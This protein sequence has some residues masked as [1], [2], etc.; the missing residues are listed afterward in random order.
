MDDDDPVVASYDVFL[1]DP[2]ASSTSD[3][4]SRLFVLQYP[5]QFR[6]HY[7]PYNA[8][9]GQAPTSLRV[10]PHTGFIE[11]DVPVVTH[12]YY[13][14]DTGKKY[15][16]AVV[17]SRIVQH[18][19]SH[20]LAGGFAN[21]PLQPTDTSSQ[22]QPPRLA[23]PLHSQTLGGK[24]VTPSQRDPTYLVG[25]L[26]GNQIH[27]SHL[28]ALVQMRSQLH[29][30]DAQDEINQK[31][32]QSGNSS[33]AAR[34]KSGM[35]PAGKTD[36]KPLDIKI[37]HSS[38][39]P[40]D[41]SLNENARLLRDIQVDQWQ[42]HD[43]VDEDDIDSKVVLKRHLYPPADTTR[44][45][46][47][48]QS[49]ISNGDWLDRMS[50][51]REDGKKGLLAKLRGRERERAR[52][53]KA[54]EEKRQ[55]QKETTNARPSTHGPLMDMSSDSDMSSPD[56]SDSDMGQDATIS[57]TTEADKV[58]IKEEPTAAPIQSSSLG[59]SA[60]GPATTNPPKKR[61]RPRKSQPT[62][63]MP[64]ED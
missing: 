51:P 58:T 44:P 57:R 42:Q 41:R 2:L 37:G 11:V 36:S 27:L 45:K 53:K 46:V 1:T 32:F 34:Q 60:P 23:A 22:D 28:D 16:K 48:L 40:K 61:G 43:W 39:D 50:A 56:A 12:K 14:E 9:N 13:N 18:G 30:I 29:Q 62:E 8:A 35:E 15:A 33:T 7:K 49:S 31:R 19:G 25:C 17:E 21:G 63:S 54:E 59:P 47:R 64:V 52:R 10:K 4:S 24:I 26:Q 3:S 6:Q 55:K 38:N 5:L 20:G